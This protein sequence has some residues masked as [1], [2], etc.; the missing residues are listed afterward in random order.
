MSKKNKKQQPDKSKELL[1]VGAV[2]LVLVIVVI[3]LAISLP[4]T[5]TDTTACTDPNH[6]HSHDHS[7]E[8]TEA[9]QHQGDGDGATLETAQATHYVT[10]EIADYGTIKAELYGNTAPKTVQNFVELAQKG[11]YN[12]LNFHR[13]IEGFMMQGGAPGADSEPVASINGEFTDNGFTNNLLHLRG[14]LSMARTS[15]P[16][17]ASSQFFIIHQDSPHLDGQYAAF[18]MVTEGMDVVDAVCT[19]AEP[20]DGNGAIAEDA[21]PVI[22]SLTVTEA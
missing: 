16:N 4:G 21:R 22:T 11:Y 7:H 20:T 8:Q 15:E 13:I 6:D 2:A 9:T 19:A 12:G 3:I 17:S 5:P 18:G 14:V 10:I 1:I